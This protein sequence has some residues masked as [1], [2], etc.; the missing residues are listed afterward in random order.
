MNLNRYDYFAFI[1][2]WEGTKNFKDKSKAEQQ[3]LRKFFAKYQ[4][5]VLSESSY[6]RPDKQERIA[7]IRK[8]AGIVEEDI[9][10]LLEEDIQL[11]SGAGIESIPELADISVMGMGDED[12]LDKPDIHR[13]VD[14]F[15]AKSRTSS[16]RE[17]LLKEHNVKTRA[18]FN[19]LLSQRVLALHEQFL[20][21]TRQALNLQLEALQQSS[22]IS[23]TKTQL[24][25]SALIESV[26][27]TKAIQ[28]DVAK[29]VNIS[30]GGQNWDDVK[31]R[32]LPKWF[33]IKL[34]SGLKR[35]AVSTLMLP[36][37]GPVAII[38]GVIIEPLR[39]VGK[40]VDSVL[41]ILQELWGWTMV[42]FC[43]AGVVV[44]VQHPDYDKERQAIYEAYA[45]AINYIPV[46][47]IISP[48]NE[49]IKILWGAV[50]GQKFFFDVLDVMYVSMSVVPMLVVRWV[51]YLVQNLA[52]FLKSV[53]V[54]AV[55]AWWN[56]EK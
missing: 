13:A 12:K 5:A 34:V 43:I 37:T 52:I 6:N 8:Q 45:T 10:R 17:E 42:G 51:T 25:G 48:T 21:D 41:K 27:A 35:L 47:Y 19:E 29:L 39:L 1:I 33:R 22:L 50:P 11:L 14:D 30:L 53:I 4:I 3:F 24:D 9:L 28:A 20:H 55:K 16:D 54:E 46:D 36:L 18:E 2:F 44:I 56:N 23:D 32:D 49:T 15:Y 7:Y 40:R 26:N 31:L 38:N